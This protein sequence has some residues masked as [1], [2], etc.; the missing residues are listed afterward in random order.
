MPNTVA[1]KQGKGIY[2]SFFKVCSLILLVDAIVISDSFVLSMY[3]RSEKMG[4]SC[5]L[6]IGLL[7]QNRQCVVWCGLTRNT[8][9]QFFRLLVCQL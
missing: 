8:F 7:A 2:T 5:R 4:W 6:G 9:I 1:Y 3:I